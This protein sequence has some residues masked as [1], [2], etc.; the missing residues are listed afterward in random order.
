MGGVAASLFFSKLYAQETEKKEATTS[1][2]STNGIQVTTVDQKQKTQ[3]SIANK[4]LD[5]VVVVGYGTQQKKLVTSAISTIKSTAF[6]QT[7]IMRADD[8]LQGKAAGVQIAANSG[9]PGTAMN[10]V[11]RGV[12]TNGNYQPI[13]IVDGIPVSSIEYLNPYDIESIEVLKDAASAAIYGARGG[14]GVILVT[15]KKGSKGRA[16]IQYNFN[17][18]WQNIARTIPVLNAKEYCIVQ[19]Q[20]AFNS[21]TTAPFTQAQINSFNQGTNWQQAVLNPN[22]P[23]MQHQLSVSGGDD[24]SSYNASASYLNQDGII[25][26]GK[27]NFQRYTVS[28]NASRYFLDKH[29]FVGS[30]AALT[31]VNRQSI[32]QNSLT[33]GPLVG[34]LN[35]DPLTPV[36]DPYNPDPLYGGFGTSKYVSQEVVNPVARIHF[37]YGNQYY[38][39]LIGSAFAEANFLKDFKLRSTIATELTW[40]GSYGYTP[41]YKLNSATGNT[42]ANGASQSMDQYYTLNWENTLHWS[43]IYNEVHNVSALVGTTYIKNT[44][45]FLSGNRN[46]LIIN[47]PEYAFLSMATSTMP[48][49]SGGLNNPSSLLSYFGRVNYAY[50]NKYMLT[51]IFRADGSS[52]FGSNNRFGYFPSVSAGWN[53]AQEQ[54]MKPVHK[55]LNELKIRA[56]WGQNGNQNIGDFR[57]L[58]TISTYGLGYVFGS[59]IPTQSIATGAAPTN[60]PNPN[61]KWE[62][63][64]QIDVGFD[65]L[66][67]NALTI[68]MDYYHK[69]TKGLLLTTPIPLFLGNSFPTMNAGNVI[70]QGVE[71]AIGYQHTVNGFHFEINGNIAYNHNKVTAVNTATGFVA[72]PTIQGLSG[73]VTRMQAGYP[74]AY[75]WGYKTLGIFQNQQQVSDYHYTN[76]TTGVTNLIQPNARPGDLIWQDTNGDGK[77]DDNDRVNLGSP[78]PKI[79][80]GLNLSMSY[81]GFDLSITTAG[82][83]GSKIISVLRRVDLPMSNYQTWILG[84][85]HG[86][87]TSNTI[88]RVTSTV[89][90]NKNWSTFSD[91]YVKSG[92]YWRIRNI[93]L[94]YTFTIPKGYYISKVRIYASVSNPFTITAYQGYDPEIGSSDPLSAGIDRGVYPHPRTYTI[95]A[96]VTF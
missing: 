79:I 26:K 74:M 72:G 69:T 59:Q 64:E 85:W 12:G 22:A 67:F 32:S 16:N 2:E 33:A 3:D 90:P 80:F 39:K 94:G 7:G 76:P 93:T 88:P 60:V 5:E 18:G 28:L 9:Q 40:N 87:G 52:R 38:Y 56:S 27:S 62:T 43:H 81:W 77:I 4:L 21:G 47:S 45:T 84:S 29:F 48:G 35:M 68:T 91:L 20:A 61:L 86:E 49:V 11:V 53:M 70:N 75:F 63:S 95:G 15:T 17:Y 31:Y 92:D 13:Y 50:D 25:A 1:T 54:F 36:Y 58:P 44:S 42:T 57:Y 14:N 89:D 66:L 73:S 46:D 82:T 34:A 30:N 10:I 65:A 37:S 78:F 55:W 6:E 8:A 19:N 71:L 96:S 51:A 24:V 23:M 83:W 41:M